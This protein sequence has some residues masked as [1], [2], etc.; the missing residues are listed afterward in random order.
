MAA[1]SPLLL[2]AFLAPDRLGR[3]LDTLALVGLGGRTLR[4]D[5]RRNLTDALTCRRPLISMAVGFTDLHLDAGPGSGNLDR[6]G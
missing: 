6:R 2:L 5:L 4:P 3:V 1:I